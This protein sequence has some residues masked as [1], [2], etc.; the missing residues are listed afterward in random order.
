MDIDI[1]KQYV[2]I[3]IVEIKGPRRHCIVIAQL[4]LL[5]TQTHRF[6]NGVHMEGTKV[7]SISWNYR[8]R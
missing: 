5:S 7:F 4:F 6:A 8:A 3:E 1:E 2:L